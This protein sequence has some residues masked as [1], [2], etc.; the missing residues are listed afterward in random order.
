MELTTF[1]RIVLLWS[2]FDRSARKLGKPYSAVWLSEPLQ[3][4]WFYNQLP[5]AAENILK[6]TMQP[7]NICCEVFTTCKFKQCFKTPV[8]VWLGKTNCWTKGRDIFCSLSMTD[9][10]FSSAAWVPK[11]TTIMHL[12]IPD[13]TSVQGRQFAHR[14]L[15]R[16]VGEDRKMRQL[17]NTEQVCRESIQ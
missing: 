16:D 4:Y 11:D 10:A 15:R 1:V 13:F 8:L 9:D 5:F 2:S 12:L 14:V 17:W 3:R 6:H 7:L